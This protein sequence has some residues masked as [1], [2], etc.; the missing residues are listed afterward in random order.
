[1]TWDWIAV[2]TAFL[3]STLALLY[4][5]GWAKEHRVILKRRIWVVVTFAVFGVFIV[6]SSLVRSLTLALE[7]SSLGLAALVG[8]GIDLLVIIF[9][10]SWLMRFVTGKIPAPKPVPVTLE[11]EAFL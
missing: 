2:A 9:E 1:M 10:I 6:Q 4:L 8:V 7:Q 3:W 5:G 11:L